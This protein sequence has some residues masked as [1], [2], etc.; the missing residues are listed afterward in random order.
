MQVIKPCGKPRFHV[1]LSGRVETVGGRWLRGEGRWLRGPTWEA[2][3]QAL[4]RGVEWGRVG[5]LW[6]LP[7]FPPLESLS[8]GLNAW[9][10][11]VHSSFIRAL[12]E[13][14]EVLELE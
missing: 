7:A 11:E 8:F 1:L 5:A 12:G 2:G 9:K 13:I 14:E 3:A 6:P 10:K 4:E